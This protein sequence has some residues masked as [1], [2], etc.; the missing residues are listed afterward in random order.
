M[1]KDEA[2]EMAI[3][4][5]RSYQ[6]YYMN[7]AINACKEA[8]EQPSKLTR[9]EVIDNNGRAY[10]NMAIDKLQFSYQDEGRTLKIFT[11]GAGAI[12]PAQ[13]PIYIIGEGWNCDK[14]P[15]LGT[16]LYTHPHQ[17]QGLTD[18]EIARLVLIN[19]VDK[20]GDT[21]FARLIEQA[22]KEKNYG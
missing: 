6:K 18:D 22:L 2:L 10:V 4:A 17:W 3:D 1:D 8:L 5:M 9:L 12:Q 7:R 21:G 16:K 15:E 11:N 20:S 19:E 13:E 14:F